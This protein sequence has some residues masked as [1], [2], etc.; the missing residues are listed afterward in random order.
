MDQGLV[1]RIPFDA[2]VGD[3]LTVSADGDGTSNGVDPLLVVLDTSN[4]PLISDDDS[5]GSVNAAITKYALP[6]DGSYTLVVS[7]SGGGSI[8]TV[9]VQFDLSQ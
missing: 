6:A 5:G 2:K 1:Y 4:K 3:K 9:T 8:G 7:Y